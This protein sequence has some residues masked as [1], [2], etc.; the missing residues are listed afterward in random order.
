M[1]WI[2]S[3]L[4]E[5][6]V[7]PPNWLPTGNDRRARARSIVHRVFERRAMHKAW[8]PGHYLHDLGWAYPFFGGGRFV[9]GDE[10]EAELEDELTHLNPPI[11]QGWGIA[12]AVAIAIA[13]LFVLRAAGNPQHGDALPV[14]LAAFLGF[15]GLWVAIE[16]LAGW[17]EREVEPLP[18]RRGRSPLD[19]HLVPSARTRA[20]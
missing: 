14:A 15:L 9:S 16:I 5:S 4:L 10:V 12:F 6:P 18:A 8:H 1:G 7:P 17:Q 19:G 3:L 11:L 13:F 20:G 2:A